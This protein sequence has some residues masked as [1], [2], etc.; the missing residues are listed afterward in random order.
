MQEKVWRPQEVLGAHGHSRADLHG[1]PGNDT[2][3]GRG[4]GE[5]GDD[6]L[7]K[8]GGMYTVA[9]ASH[10]VTWDAFD[11]AVDAAVR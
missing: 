8:V 4:D 3:C 5:D 1:G 10:R 11:V 7:H 6:I 9:T 2:M